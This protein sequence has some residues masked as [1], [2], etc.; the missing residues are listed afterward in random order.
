MGGIEASRGWNAVRNGS[1]SCWFLWEESCR[2]WSMETAEENEILRGFLLR[3]SVIGSVVRVEVQLEG[4]LLKEVK[5][6]G[7]SI[8][9]TMQG[10]KVTVGDGRFAIVITTRGGKEVKY[11]AEEQRD[12]HRWL[13]ALRASAMS[14]FSFYYRLGQRIGAGHFGSIHE[15]ICKRTNKSFAVK[16][17]PRCSKTT[18]T[19]CQVLAEL[20]VVKSVES[21][22]LVRT[23]ETF[24]SGRN[25]YI[26]M[27]LI[28]HG[29][30]A[31]LLAK[32]GRM[33]EAHAG[34]IMYQVF[35]G[36]SVL[37]SKG[38]VHRDVKLE[39]ILVQDRDNVKVKLADF[40][41]SRINGEQNE[42]AVNRQD[43]PKKLS[44][45]VGTYEYMAP[46]ILRSNKYG[47]AVDLW[48]CGVVL[49]ALL[50][51]Q[52]PFKSENHSERIRKLL[53]GE[54]SP[55]PTALRRSPP[56]AHSTLRGSFSLQ[57]GTDFLSKSF[58]S[59]CQST[60]QIEM[61]GEA[62]EEVSEGAK[63]MIRSLLQVE[64]EQRLTVQEA[65]RHPWIQTW[66]PDVLD[67]GTKPSRIQSFASN[68]RRDSSS[69][70][71]AEAWKRKRA[72]S[73]RFK[74]VS[75]RRI[76]ELAKSVRSLRTLATESNNNSTVTAVESP[77]SS[78][79]GRE[80]ASQSG[81]LRT[82]ERNE[83]ATLPEKWKSL[84]TLS[85]IPVRMN[86]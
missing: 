41:L 19:T 9:M 68:L 67:K 32:R 26:V 29:E 77:S 83:S 4:F 69:E 18:E 84:R 64:E 14:Q 46:E 57:K 53:N 42:E 27:E 71:M 72:S 15:C 81:D 22:F 35:S 7:T 24:Q 34:R 86:T 44:R 74:A 80:I 23:Y 65:I 47:S 17:L 45:Q 52:F 50:C 82:L 70:D 78:K 63:D 12:F 1:S 76:G 48:A 37:H 55:A 16:I 62:W 5:R 2:K 59:S 25:V 39:N 38:I 49:Y 73:D 8:P 31:D 75:P 28:S 85:W 33:T 79:T 61:S 3:R 6:V 11:Y 20:E 58:L 66:L 21:E 36:L 60:L 40:G 54:V 51:K 13:D 56:P 10:C 30:C 43:Y